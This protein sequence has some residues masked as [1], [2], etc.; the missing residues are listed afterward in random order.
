MSLINDLPL[1][2][3][4]FDV[5]MSKIMDRITFR[6]KGLY[7]NLHL[8]ESKSEETILSKTSVSSLHKNNFNDF[9]KINQHKILLKKVRSD[10]D[11][12]SLYFNNNN[13]KMKKKSIFNPKPIDSE[14]SQKFS[15]ASIAHTN[16][17]TDLGSLKETK[18]GKKTDRFETSSQ[19]Y[20]NY[21]VRCL[22]DNIVSTDF[23]LCSNADFNFSEFIY[24][25]AQL[26]KL[27]KSYKINNL[28]EI[29]DKSH[30]LSKISL[31][32]SSPLFNENGDKPNLPCFYRENLDKI[33]CKINSYNPFSNGNCN[34]ELNFEF[35]NLNLS[36]DK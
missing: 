16:S 34:K 21:L 1:N 7:R 6:S 31:N 3:D 11:H 19:K 28:D 36:Y 17:L 27:I 20:K 5:S 14:I 30:C 35:E 23:K 26:I 25:K 24:S 8:S 10:S 33:A 22:K 4:I 2:N 18:C 13:N 15:A 12:D 9:T 32:E 29:V